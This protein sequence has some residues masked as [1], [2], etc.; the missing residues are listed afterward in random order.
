MEEGTH[1][2]L[3]ESKGLYRKLWDR[4]TEQSEHEAKEIAQKKL[5]EEELKK[6]REERLRKRRSTQMKK[7][8]EEGKESEEANQNPTD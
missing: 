3:Y 5:E 4:Q 2:Q 6:E 8:T 1:E 7:D